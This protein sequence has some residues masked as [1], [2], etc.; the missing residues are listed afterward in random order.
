MARAYPVPTL[1][2]QIETEW[3]A[4]LA[5]HF[6]RTAAEILQPLRPWFDFPQGQLR[7]ELMDGSTMQFVH[8]FHLVNEPKRTIAVFTEHCGHHL[9]PYHEA[10]IF[11][12]DVLIYAQST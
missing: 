2:T 9:Y 12:D 1:A 6:G 11:R 7:I 3:A 5:S 8:A 10:R 4:E